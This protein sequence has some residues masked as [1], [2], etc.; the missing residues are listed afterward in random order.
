MIGVCLVLGIIA[1]A[2]LFLGRAQE[3]SRTPGQQPPANGAPPANPLQVA[4]LK[5]YKINLTTSF[6][7]PENPI[8]VA[9]DGENIWMS[10]ATAGSVVKLRVSD[11]TNLGT[12][13]VGAQ[14]MGMVFDGANIWVANSYG[15]TVSK[16]RASDGKVLGTFSVG[17][18]PWYLAFDGQ[19][20]W[21]TNVGEATISEL[22]ASDGT[23]IGT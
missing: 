10:A 19:N 8:G 4:L 2:S 12:F 13:S 15:N 16:L 11:G 14:P 18:M 5:W 17:K 3:A 6:K 1:S 20:I 21:V 22:R 7:V 23:L 9:F